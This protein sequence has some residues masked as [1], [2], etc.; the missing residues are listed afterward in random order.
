MSLFNA[1]LRGLCV[2]W[3]NLGGDEGQHINAG[4]EDKAPIQD[5]GKRPFVKL[6][7]RWVDNIKKKLRVVGVRMGDG[8]NLLSITRLCFQWHRIFRI[9]Q[10]VS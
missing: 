1:E 6:Q 7:R 5:L 8:Q 4:R 3:Y 9:Y 10:R 2:C